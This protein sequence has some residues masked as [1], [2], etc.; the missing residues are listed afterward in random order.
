MKKIR[1]NI[2]DFLIILAVI[3]VS[4]AGVY[5]LGSKSETVVNTQ[6]TKALVMIELKNVD[7]S[8]KADYEEKAKIGSLA[9]IGIR[10]KTVGELK[11]ID[12]TEA[13][14][15]CFDLKNEEIKLA[16]VEGRYDIKFVFE[17]ELDETDKD[18]LIG[19]DKIKIGK[20]LGFGAKGYSGYGIVIGIEKVGGEK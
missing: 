14:K 6:K 8:T 10:E 5:I 7:E 19:T 13:T 12:I 15:E 2:I 3:L 20:E 11:K 1:F 16:K 4:V 9:N 17:V 18:F